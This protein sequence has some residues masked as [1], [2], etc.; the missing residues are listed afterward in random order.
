MI[1]RLRLW[2]SSRRAL[3]AEVESLRQQRTD[4][5]VALRN[6]EARLGAQLAAMRAE[7]TALDEAFQQQRRDLE[8]ERMWG[9]R[10]AHRVVLAMDWS[11]GLPAGQGVELRRLLSPPFPGCVPAVVEE[12][13][14]AAV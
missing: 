12:S 7:A 13:S 2:F 11:S 10:I 1:R 14:N 4:L 6:S 8:W 9:N 5:L 3:A